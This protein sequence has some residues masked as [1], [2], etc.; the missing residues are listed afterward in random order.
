MREL[1]KLR[2]GGNVPKAG[3]RYRA[4]AWLTHWVE[5]I[6]APPNV[7]ENAHSGYEMDVRVHL[8]PGIG[9]HW[10]DKLQADDLEKAQRKDDP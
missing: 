10:L 7:S 2:D 8:I 4:A 9:G 5:N 3:Q 6:A 1:E